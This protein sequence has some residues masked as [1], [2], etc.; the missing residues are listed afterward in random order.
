MT[1]NSQAL[2]RDGF[3]MAVMK[4]CLLPASL[5]S[6]RSWLKV[7]SDHE[8]VGTCRYRDRFHSVVTSCRL[9]T[10]T[11][12]QLTAIPRMS[13]WRLQSMIQ[14]LT[15][16]KWKVEADTFRNLIDCQ[17]SYWELPQVFGDKSG[18]TTDF[19]YFS[20]SLTSAETVNRYN[21]WSVLF[22]VFMW[23]NHISKLNITL[24]SEVLVSSDKI[25]Y[26]NLTFHNV[27]AGQGSSHCNGARLNFSVA[28]HDSRG[29]R[30]LSRDRGGQKKLKS[31]LT[32]QCLH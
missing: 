12:T 5:S 32:K 19:W 20:L 29:P 6:F 26:R 8:R 14:V 3:A 30:K 1:R 28:W 23:R 16:R 10:L 25:P 2:K 9:P 24:P 27:L 17:L 21:H 11:L 4:V 31:Y 15:K 18:S 22:L 7:K 13:M